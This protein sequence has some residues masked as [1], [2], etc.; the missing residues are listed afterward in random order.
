MQQAV[1]LARVQNPSLLAADAHVTATRQ[2]E[3][4]AGLRVNPNFNL[5]GSDV[6]LAANSNNP[7]FYSGQ[8]S[9]L[10]ERG[11]KRRWRLDIAHST[12]D[13]TRSQYADQERQAVLAVKTSFT[14]MLGAKGAF[15]LAKQNLDDY[16]KTIDLSRERMRA[17]DISATDFKRLDLQLAQFESDYD[18]AHT[19]L[20]QASEQLQTLLGYDRPH[21]GFD[22]TGSLD[23]PSISTTPPAC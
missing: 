7:Y 18:N 15:D 14:Q 2:S 8:V 23:P 9:R 20:V 6:S 10:F 17:G 21:P 16:R 3:I 13:V 4:T 12:T 1:D 22:I 19:N 11:Q 5:T